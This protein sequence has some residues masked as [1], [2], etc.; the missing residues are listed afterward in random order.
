MN[1][2]IDISYH[3]GSILFTAVKND[4][5]K[6]IIR[7]GYGNDDVKQ[8]DKK[9]VTYITEALKQKI[10]VA[11]YIYSYATNTDMAISEADHIVRLAKPYKG[12]ISDTLW[13][14][15]EEQKAMNNAL[16]IFNAF[17]KRV[18]GYGWKVGLYTGEYY[19]NSTD[20]V[21]ISDDVPLWIAKYGSNNGSPQTAPTLKNNKK[22]SMWQ[23]TS[24]G[25]ISGINGGVDLSEC[26]RTDLFTTGESK[27]TI[28]EAIK[29]LYAKG[30]I[31]TPQY[32]YN[33][34]KI[35]NYLEPLLINMADSLEG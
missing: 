28:D 4:V 23:Y 6:A 2:V 22:V 30:V 35:V 13:F 26:W 8:D 18:E 32:W 5:D 12:I 21:N 11:L 34:I 33:A 3:N 15:I 19:F 17:K 9:F 10:A 20:L 29:K 1:K 31:S 14:D 27:T 25:T 7:C 24:K 16:A